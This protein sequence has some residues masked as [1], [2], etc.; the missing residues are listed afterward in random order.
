[1]TT[2]R[3]WAHVRS[4]RSLRALGAGA[5]YWRNRPAPSLPDLVSAADRHDP[6]APQQQELAH[7]SPP[8]CLA[9][10][11]FSS[12]VKG[13]QPFCTRARSIEAMSSSE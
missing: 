5:V 10:S 6:T 13:G 11:A 12:S 1:M 2:T 3:I 4:T 7:E 9:N 8:P